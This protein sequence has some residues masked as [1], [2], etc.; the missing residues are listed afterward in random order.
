MIATE[1]IN[2]MSLDNKPEIRSRI[3]ATVLTILMIASLSVTVVTI[4]SHAV[5]TRFEA[6]SSPVE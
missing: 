6:A 3:L 4:F 5:A 2:T 1:P